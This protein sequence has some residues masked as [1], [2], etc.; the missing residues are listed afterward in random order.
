MI[1]YYQGLDEF[2]KVKVFIS[3][4]SKYGRLTKLGDEFILAGRD[5]EQG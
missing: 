5:F 1:P 3:T 4:L 2:F